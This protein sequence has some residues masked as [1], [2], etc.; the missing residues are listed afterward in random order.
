ML[1]KLLDFSK[2]VH[3]DAFARELARATPEFIAIFKLEKLLQMEA[4]RKA[5]LHILKVYVERR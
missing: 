1:S 4:S 5:V 2:N 3:A